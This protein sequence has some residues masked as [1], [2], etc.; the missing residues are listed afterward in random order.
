MRE[1]SRAWPTQ[2]YDFVFFSLLY[3]YVFFLSFFFLLLPFA[4]CVS[5]VGIVYIGYIC[6]CIFMIGVRSLLCCGRLFAYGCAAIVKIL[7]FHIISATYA[8]CV[9]V[10]ELYTRLYL[11]YIWRFHVI[12]M[13]Q[14]EWN[15]HQRIFFLSIFARSLIAMIMW[16]KQIRR[17]YEY[18]I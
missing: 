14:W 15:E 13:R 3:Y 8:V 10:C 5:Y 18:C 4:L 17:R 16:N 9:C 12:H 2:S 11:L 1:K 7:H 6:I